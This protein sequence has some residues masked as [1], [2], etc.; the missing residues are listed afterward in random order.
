MLSDARNKLH[1]KLFMSLAL[2]LFFFHLARM[3]QRLLLRVVI[4]EDDIRKVTLTERPLHVEDLIRLLKGKLKLQ[5]DFNMQ[6]ED[7]NAF[8]I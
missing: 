2:F 6:Y 8:V 5:Y 3:D 4:T 1:I 7:F